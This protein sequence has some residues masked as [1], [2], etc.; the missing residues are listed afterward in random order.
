MMAYASESG[1]FYTIDGEPAYEIEMKS[2]PGEMRA[3]TV[4]D[5]RKLGLVP[6]V[7]TVLNVLSKPGLEQW[8]R[9]NI[10][11][12]ALTLP[13][14]DGESL[15]DYA[16]RVE[17]DAAEQAKKAA[18]RGTRIHGSI[19]RAFLGLDYDEQ[20]VPFVE[21]AFREVEKIAPIDQWRAERSF[22]HPLGYGGKCD[23]YTPGIDTPGI[24]VDFKTKE[25]SEGA[26]LGFPE[27]AYQLAAYREGF[28]M[29]RARGINIFISVSEPGLALPIEWKEDDLDSGWSV[30]KH[31]LEIW[32]LTKKY[33]PAGAFWRTT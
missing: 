26:K 20:D 11:H 8:K 13:M 2:R 29:P 33:D 3:T 5:A 7:T 28:E 27:Q 25:F 10:L 12:S 4:R 31:A 18:E 1:H 16:K 23:L 32:K 22:S 17:I 19:E 14:I 15:D 6:S 30:F 24:V 9:T 21:A